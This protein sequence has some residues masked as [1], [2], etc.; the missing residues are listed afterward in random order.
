MDGYS[1]WFNISQVFLLSIIH[2][3]LENY[4]KELF[5]SETGSYLDILVGWF[6][7]VNCKGARMSSMT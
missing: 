3:F 1:P 7:I 6:R 2:L 5:A 4:Y